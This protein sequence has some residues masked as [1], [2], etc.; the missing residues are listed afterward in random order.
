MFTQQAPAIIK[1]LSG[2]LPDNAVRS[3]VQALGNC[4]QPLAHRGDVNLAPK[5]PANTKGV[6]GNNGWNPQQYQNLFPTE[7][8]QYYMEAPQVGS[9]SNGNWYSTNYGGA[10]FAFPL[11]QEFNANEYYGGPTFNVGG[12]SFFNNTF[13][14]TANYNS[15]TTENITTETMNGFP[16]PVLQ[17]TDPVGGAVPPPSAVGSIPA[18]QYAPN[19]FGDAGFVG[20]R[21]Q[22]ATRALLANVDI[23]ATVKVPYFKNFR[24]SN[25]C[26]VDYDESVVE[27]PVRLRVIPQL[28]TLTY[29]KP[30]D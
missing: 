2:V 18:I 25:D 1:A 24:W 12:N 8:Q 4:Q 15:V 11:N 5:E 30:V 21:G 17:P 27:L 13:A 9:Y 19:F 20:V 26:T 23:E 10:Q 14:N 16:V 7:Y 6:L 29:L 28:T 22:R 3:L